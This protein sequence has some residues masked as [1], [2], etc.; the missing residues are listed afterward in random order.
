MSAA[1]LWLNFERMARIFYVL[2]Q[3]KSRGAPPT[4]IPRNSCTILPGLISG[5]YFDVLMLIRHIALQ[6][7][8]LPPN[9]HLDISKNQQVSPD[10][11]YDIPSHEFELALR[12]PLKNQERYSLL[13]V[14][15]LLRMRLSL[16][17]PSEN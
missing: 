4:A 9:M 7:L 1:D 17:S 16:A 3:G 8:T 15:V 10:A 5:S 14:V 2:K 6:T 11:G 13:L 12:H